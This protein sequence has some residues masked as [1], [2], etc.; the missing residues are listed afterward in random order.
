MR[1]VSVVMRS[2]L[3]VVFFIPLFFLANNVREVI[4][5]MQKS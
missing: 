2:L 5:W 3:V 1:H 4:E